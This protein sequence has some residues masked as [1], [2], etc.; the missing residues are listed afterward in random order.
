M[1]ASEDFLEALFSMSVG[2][3]KV[4]DCLYLGVKDKISHGMKSCVS[5]Y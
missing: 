5:V 3:P 2:V 4:D 1:Q